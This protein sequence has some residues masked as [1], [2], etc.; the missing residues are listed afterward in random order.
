MK[1]TTFW[2]MLFACFIFFNGRMQAQVNGIATDPV[3]STIE[4]PIYF[5]I[6]SASDGSVLY[7]GAQHTEDTRGNVII[8]PDQRGTRLRHNKLETAP[9]PD[10]AL[11]A[12]VDVNGQNYLKNK[13]T[14]F[15][16]I[17]CHTADTLTTTNSFRSLAL[18]Q[19][20]FLIRTADQG[21]YTIA[22]QNNTCDRWSN[23]GMVVNGL[24]AWYF[25]VADPDKLETVLRSALFDKIEEAKWLLK[26]TK[27]GNDFGQYTQF[28][29]DEIADDLENAQLV[30]DFPES[31][32]SDLNLTL[33]YLSQAVESYKLNINTNPAVLETKD[34][35]K[36][37]WY[38]IRNF[39]YDT[40]F[41]YN[42]VIAYNDKLPGEKYTFLNKV[43]LPAEY[44]LFRFELSED[45][46]KVVN[47]VDMNGHYMSPY[48]GILAEPAMGIEWELLPQSDGIAFW[49][50]PTGIAPLR[51][52][53][54]TT[55]S[56]W[57]Y[58][59]GGASSWVLDFAVKAPKIPRFDN[60]RS[61][62][63]T[64]ANAAQ[65]SA[66]ITE[67]GETSITTDIVS[68]SVT[69]EP[70]SGYFFLQWTNANGDSIST[71]NPFVY[72][73]E[74]EIVLVAVF[75]PGYYRPMQRFFTGPSPAVQSA[76]RYLTDVKVIIGE[77]EQI[78]MSDVASSPNPV[79]TT[80]LRNQ[81]IDDAVVDFTFVP[82]II[83]LDTDTIDLMCKGSNQTN[84]N[85]QWTQQN[86]FIDWNKDYDFLD[87]FEAGVR[88]SSSYTDQRHVQEDGFTRKIGIPEGLEEG[89]YRMRIIY[90]EPSNAA[91]DWSQTIWNNNIIRNGTAY[92]FTI[93]YG[94]PTGLK[95]SV[96]TNIVAF[97]NE[98][99]LIVKNAA[100]SKLTITD[101]TGKTLHVVTLNAD[102]V[103]IPVAM[104]K[105][106]YLLGFTTSN[107]NKVAVKVVR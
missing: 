10:Y 40:P 11:W 69:A 63:T 54:N 91:A 39:G 72:K 29:R 62:T 24:V 41:A 28:S 35:N 82:I 42:Q 76:D 94:S 103:M 88:S 7:G 95:P 86:V 16:M 101:L 75:E 58:M 73:G 65:G 93:Q 17:G 71:H 90:H 33:D 46:S 15:Y 100:D 77:T 6:E 12:I 85:F 30:Y 2:L 4:D 53:E 18:S 37:K 78:I 13:A 27:V 38:W 44:Q 52:D 80:V 87:E 32:I 9:N 60:P 31:S 56:N 74:E 21:S 97:F 51:A 8:S 83:P 23:T 81:L 36:Y 89:N 61:I 25:I 92:D 68:V 5:Y 64:S 84:E 57:L 59:A 67:T 99:H 106:V 96:K 50:K 48:G 1:K 55:I 45:S 105:G 107:G 26:E 70:N 19:G 43:E 98:N 79:D 104:D 47:I 22:W 20:Q 49:I 66:Y 34:T 3:V 14:G 102:N